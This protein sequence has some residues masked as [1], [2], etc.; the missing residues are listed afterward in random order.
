MRVFIEA[1]GVVYELD[2]TTSVSY[3]QTAKA[4]SHPVQAGGNVSDHVTQESDTI[5]IS[6]VAS[7]VKFG[8]NEVI[9]LKQFLI[10]LQKLKRAGKTFTVTFSDVLDVL[11]NCVFENI[12][13]TISAGSGLA[14]QMS[15][16]I[17]QIRRAS[18]GKKVDSPVRAANFE[19]KAQEQQQTQGNQ[20][21]IPKRD[22]ADE[23]IA[24]V[25]NDPNATIETL[26]NYRANK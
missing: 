21:D 24:Q 3:V 18:R 13:D 14:H 15:F 11:T 20:K 5:Q 12:T 9:E 16:S 2:A 10:G 19:K 7:Q 17:K 22:I 1:E 23:G 6:G 4:T 26:G 25:N 8:G